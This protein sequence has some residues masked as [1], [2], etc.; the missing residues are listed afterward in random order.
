[1]G[2][3]YTN[4]IR[5]TY[6]LHQG[7]TPSGKPKWYFSRK[8]PVKPVTEIPDGFEVYENP[9]R[10]VFLRRIVPQVITDAELGIV[11]SA[12]RE[13]AATKYWL[14]ERKGEHVTIHAAKSLNTA[15]WA[16]MGSL[17][18][19]ASADDKLREAIESNLDYKPMFRL[20]LANETGREFMIERWC[21][22]GSID[23][24]YMLD[25]GQLQPLIRRYAPHLGAES[26]F[27][28]M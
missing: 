18:L 10:Q 7:T 5:Q 22:R 3:E 17:G 20:T 14:A 2:I 21:F 9:D 25:G 28:L 15:R 6:Y 27:E 13:L 19:G 4:R 12:L 23:G 1:M 26:F 8:I 11:R 24:W 16:L